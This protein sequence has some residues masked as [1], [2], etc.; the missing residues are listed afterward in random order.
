MIYYVI[1]EKRFKTL[2]KD[3]ASDLTY[4]ICTTPPLNAKSG[5]RNPNR[6]EL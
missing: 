4:A 1:E 5:T 2:G 6:M 3:R